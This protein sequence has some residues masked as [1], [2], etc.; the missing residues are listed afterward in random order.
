MAEIQVKVQAKQAASSRGGFSFSS[1]V[2]FRQT[3]QVPDNYLFL[4]GT[5][6]SHTQFEE[7]QR[8]PVADRGLAIVGGRVTLQEGKTRGAQESLNDYKIL[9]R[10][11]NVP[12][13]EQSEMAHY[14]WS[15]YNR[16][17]GL[18]RPRIN[19]HSADA[20]A[21]QE[22]TAGSAEVLGAL[23][24][25][26]GL[27]VGS[28]A[29]KG[30]GKGIAWLAAKEAA[31]RAAI[32]KGVEWTAGAGFA[33]M[34]GYHTATSMGENIIGPWVG[35]V[36][37]KAGLFSTLSG[38]M[39]PGPD[40]P[41]S[42]GL[43]TG[44]NRFMGMVA[45]LLIGAWGKSLFKGGSKGKLNENDMIPSESGANK[46]DEAKSSQSF[47]IGILK[48]FGLDATTLAKIIEQPAGSDGKP[49]VFSRPLEPGTSYFRGIKPFKE[50]LAHEMGHHLDAITKG[51]GRAAGNLISGIG[52]LAPNLIKAIKEGY[53]ER[54][55]NP[56]NLDKEIFAFGFSKPFNPL[57]RIGKA[58][59]DAFGD[60]K[61]AELLGDSIQSVISAAKEMGYGFLRGRSVSEVKGMRE[62]LSQKIKEIEAAKGDAA[63]LKERLAELDRFIESDGQTLPKSEASFEIDTNE[64]LYSGKNI[65]DPRNTPGVVRPYAERELAAALGAL[66]VGFKIKGTDNYR[67]MFKK[68]AFDFVEEMVRSLFKSLTMFGSAKG[69]GGNVEKIIDL[70]EQYKQ[71]ISEGTPESL[72]RAEAIRAKAAELANKMERGEQ[73]I[74]GEFGLIDPTERN[75]KQPTSPAE[76]VDPET[77]P[78][79]GWRPPEEEGDGGGGTSVI[80]KP[81]KPKVK[82]KKETKE[83]PVP[84]PKEDPKEVAPPE[85]PPE[86]KVDSPP[87]EANPEVKPPEVVPEVVPEVKPPKPV[88][89]PEVVPEVVPVP[90]AP[91]VIPRPEIIAGVPKPKPEPK[92]KLKRVPIPPLI[93]TLTTLKPKL[94]TPTDID[95]PGFDKSAGY[96]LPVAPSFHSGQWAYPG[97]I[98]DSGRLDYN[99]D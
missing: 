81:V 13:N 91:E 61:V 59:K 7:L 15:L 78:F 65:A 96:W 4:Q 86:P 80:T 12:E 21:R 44:A 19:V 28:V 16:P 26:V 73:V 25:G 45:P 34:F 84:V 77:P 9:M 70:A 85:A 52:Q 24:G 50:A 23:L 31:R 47:V 35:K 48:S 36:S 37:D 46:N 82:T 2:T 8:M 95:F 66:G 64:G 38:G 92:I 63:N 41:L 18:Q 42:S 89:A 67:S 43:A 33:G 71:A 51:V 69:K 5:T 56:E 83:T 29:I 11:G 75:G 14:H 76:G 99:V 39:Y 49:R 22:H 54:V 88:P 27:G 40:I 93:A 53:G 58:F 20:Q 17:G 60:P 62:K 68:G 30:V 97:Y 79:E 98:I 1:D 32:E 87:V 10:K 94:T 6:L 57:S 90:D 72:A 74:E 3:L 55:K